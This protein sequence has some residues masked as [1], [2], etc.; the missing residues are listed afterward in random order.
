MY[1]LSV[2]DRFVLF[3]WTDMSDAALLMRLLTS[4][5]SCRVPDRPAA[6]GG[7]TSA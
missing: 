1:N 5:L 4:Y 7:F 2:K 3:Q 6:R